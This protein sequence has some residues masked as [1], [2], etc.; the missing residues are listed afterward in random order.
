MTRKIILHNYYPKCRVRDAGVKIP[1]PKDPKER[2]EWEAAVKK[3]EAEGRG[4]YVG[5]VSEKIKTTFSSKKFDEQTGGHGIYAR[6][7]SGKLFKLNP[8]ATGGKIPPVGSMI[9]SSEHTAVTE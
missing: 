3:R 1:P 7:E 2:A 5:D 6:T 4:K 9:N 8:R